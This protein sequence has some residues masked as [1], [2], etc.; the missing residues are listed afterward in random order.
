MQ[1]LKGTVVSVIITLYLVSHW[2]CK[3][4]QQA[5]FTLLTK[6]DT[7]IDFR[8]ILKEDENFNI[9][10][11]QYY[12][13][14]GG[15]AIADFDN[16]GLQ[17]IFFTGNMVKNRLF[18][19]TGD[20]EFEDVTET[21]GVAKAEGWCT[22][23]NAI[24]INNDGWMDI[25]VCRA[26]YPFEKLRKNLLLINNKNMTFTDRAAEYGLDDDAYSTQSAFLDYDKDGDLDMFL[27]NHSE[28]DYSKGGL[29]IFTLTHKRV[30]EK[31]SKLFRNDN[32]KYINVTEAAG[33]TGNVLSLSLGLGVIDI[34]NDGW[35]DIFIGNDFNESDYLF[36]NNGDGTFTEKAKQVFDHTSMFS[37]G[38][39]IADINN[40]GLMDLVSLDMLPES[41]YLQ[42]LHSGADNYTKISTMIEKGFQPQFSKNV[43]QINNGDGTFSEVAQLYGISNTDWSWS[44]LFT[45][46]DNDGYQDLFISN[47]YLRDHTDMDFLQFTA[48]QVVKAEKGENAVT[49]EEYLASM[50]PINQPNYFF[51]NEAGKKF[52]NK[53]KDYGLTSPSVSGASAYADLDNDGD[54]DLVVSNVGDY[55]MVYRNNNTTTATQNYINIKL[56]GS[57]NNLNAIG[58]RLYVFTKD[59]TFIKD[60]QP[61]RGFQSTVD[62][63]I[64]FGLGNRTTLDSIVVYWPDGKYQKFIGQAI[65]TTATLKYDNN[66]LYDKSFKTAATPLFVPYAAGPQ[67][68]YQA[69]RFDDLK[70][71]GLL[72]FYL[73]DRGPKSI[74][75]DF[76][77]DKLEDV[78][79]T[80]NSNSPTV[81]Y[82]QNTD[83]SFTK[84]TIPIAGKEISDIT[85]IKLGKNALYD[86]ALSVGSYKYSESEASKG[87]YI[88]K[89]NKGTFTQKTFIPTPKTNPSSIDALYV[90]GVSHLFVGGSCNFGTYPLGTA[91]LLV[92]LDAEY[93]T[94]VKDLGSI[95]LVNDVQTF[96]VNRDGTTEVFVAGDFMSIKAFSIKDNNVSDVTATYFDKTYSGLWKKLYISD[97]DGDGM[98][99]L[100]AGNFGMNA[101]LQASEAHPMLLYYHDYDKN[102]SY[103]P[104]LAHYIIDDTYP[105]A[106]R[107]D[108][109]KQVPML[110]KRFHTFSSYAKTN[111]NT[112]LGQEYTKANAP[113]SI[114]T[115]DNCYFQF[116]GGKFKKMDW[117]SEAQIAPV[118]AIS[119]MN[120]ESKN[121]VILA[122]NQSHVRV[123]LGRLNGNHGQVLTYKSKGAFSVNNRAGLN[124]RGD[125]RDIAKVKTPKGEVYILSYFNAPSQSFIVNE[126]A[127]Q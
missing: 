7:G 25:Y 127:L 80:G 36:I 75:E 20:L 47:G 12:Y 60:M 63:R 85:K 74:V 120:N 37:M 26:G 13:N 82:V 53:N 17:D 50:P 86:I 22:G 39:D 76:N 24:D 78:I 51:K 97:I 9:F 19:N 92:T 3:N 6:G 126:A 98:E 14:G 43:L 84:K 11:Y 87:I 48:D 72:P 59:Q 107:E 18:K 29:D 115:L 64:A 91:S 125:V 62:Y 93:K 2:S 55:A 95:G 119:T 32:G 96:D 61:C 49:F 108:I 104:I 41:N 15:V 27:L 110:N 16:D 123:K 116:S 69:D 38:C 105:F 122:G 54:M 118:Y 117:P 58:S 45:D 71:Q 31:E 10:K 42:K 109:I 102:G 90:N 8:N 66:K 113:L 99:E 4:E 1:M 73:S 100:L 34:N 79:I 88:F 28:P 23:A 121:D 81:L 30:K 46:F 56:Q 5:Q 112:L 40:D 68:Q 33:I 67:H 77:G 111:I 70:V 65:N 21:S 35:T 57:A 52:T 124:A 106:P 44:S 94:E 101:Q 114:N 89:N 103:D 83:G